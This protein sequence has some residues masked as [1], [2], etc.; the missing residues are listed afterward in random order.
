MLI[1]M[2]YFLILLRWLSKL[3]KIARKRQLYQSDL[4]DTLEADKCQNQLEII[5]RLVN[6]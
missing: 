4:F 3:F 1:E 5:N 6:Q 2:V